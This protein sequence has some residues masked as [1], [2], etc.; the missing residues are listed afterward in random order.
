[1]A[2]Q[3]PHSPVKSGTLTGACTHTRGTPM[4]NIRQ[5]GNPTVTVSGTCCHC[6]GERLV[7]NPLWDQFDSWKRDWSLDHPT[8]SRED[9]T[10]W[11]L[12]L[13]IEDQAETLWWSDRGYPRQDDWPDEM[14]PCSL[15]NGS[16]QLAQTWPLEEFAELLFNN[17][18]E[19][20]L[21]R[22]AAR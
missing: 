3:H 11:A 9:Q 7:P 10:A 2:N 17:V 19:R 16:G 21:R 14:I 15:C 4:P 22:R 12:H 6:V 20:P 5:L 13:V 1:M 18:Q 8:P